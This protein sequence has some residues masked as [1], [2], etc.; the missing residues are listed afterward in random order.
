MV[1]ISIRNKNLTLN[2]KK[3]IPDP[4]I[5]QLLAAIVIAFFYPQFAESDVNNLN[6]N[7]IIDTGVVLI[8]LF[9][10]LKLNKS[11]LIQD[12]SNWKMHLIIQGIVFLLFPLLIFI[13]YP[14]VPQNSA[15]QLMFVSVFYLACLPSTVSSSVVMVSIA[16]GNIPSAIFNASLSGLIGILLTPLWMSL[17]V[18]QNSELQLSEIFLDLILK[19]VLP[20]ILGLLLQPLLGKFYHQHQK[21]IAK[22][23][24]L[25]IVLI[26]YSSF[27]HTFHD[28]SFGLLGL[29]KT[30]MI[31]VIVVVLFFIVFYFSQWIGKRFK[32]SREDQI[33]IQ[34]CGTKKSLVHGSVFASVLFVDNVGIYLLPVM[35]YH[36]FQ[37]F[38]ISFIAE[39]YAKET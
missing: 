27:A 22:L 8:F 4:F 6:L 31:I 17:F 32:F 9:Y 23:D 12:L 38:T 29:S 1:K 11:A 33:T 28:G 36:T 34:F 10:G 20:V 14:L 18:Q 24:K 25:T 30:L 39:K 3:Y 15:Y 5:L 16:K 2:L 35:I 19:I 7:T 13:F 37:L 21:R 26:V